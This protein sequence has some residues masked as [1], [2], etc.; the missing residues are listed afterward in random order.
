[1]S[2][3]KNDNSNSVRGVNRRDGVGSIRGSQHTPKKPFVATKQTPAKTT[4]SST[5]KKEK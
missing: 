4:P 3:P 1:M 5:P 2:A